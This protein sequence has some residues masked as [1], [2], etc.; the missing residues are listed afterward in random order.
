MAVFD[1]D[2]R[3][4]FTTKCSLDNSLQDLCFTDVLVPSYRHFEFIVTFA[5][6]QISGPV[7]GHSQYIKC[8]N[9]VTLLFRNLDEPSKIDQIASIFRLILDI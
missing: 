5:D 2:G 1:S 9:R 7:F 8:N 6:G 3:S 4:R